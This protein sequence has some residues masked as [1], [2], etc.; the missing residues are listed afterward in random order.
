MKNIKKTTVNSKLCFDQNYGAYV[1]YMLFQNISEKRTRK[2]Y[3]ISPRETNNATPRHLSQLPIWK[4]GL[5]IL[6]ID[7]QL[8]PLIIKWIQTLLNSANALWKELIL[9]QLSLTFNSNQGLALIRQT[10]IL[11]ST[12]HK[13]LQKESNEYFCIQLLNAW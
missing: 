7:T 11:R 3:K 5:G 8:N 13:N 9:Y 4:G 6:D 12:R 1:K 2:E 10:Q